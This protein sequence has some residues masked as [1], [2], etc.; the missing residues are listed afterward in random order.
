MMLFVWKTSLR[1]CL[2]CLLWAMPTQSKAAPIPQMSPQPFLTGADLSWLPYQDWRGVKY[3]DGGGAS[4]LLVIAKR[5]HWRIIRVR[6]WVD[7]AADPRSTA[8]GLPQVTA[9]AKRIKA[10]HLVPA[11]HSLL[12]D[13]GR[14][15]PPKK[16]S[17]WE[18]L[19]FPRLVQQVQDYSRAVVTH[20]RLS[21]ALPDIVQIGN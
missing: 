7:P 5:S 4:D 13:L 9:L 2:L 19:P 12:G 15:G 11:G 8:S 20:L 1:I 6:L 16:P 18:T 10:A 3:F 21:G 17:A 14:S